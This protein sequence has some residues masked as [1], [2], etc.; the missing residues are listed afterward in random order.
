MIFEP[1]EI[2]KIFTGDYF[3]AQKKSDPDYYYC[4]LLEI[5]S[6]CRIAELTSLSKGQIKQSTDGTWFIQIRDINS[7][8][9]GC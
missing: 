4:L 3:K 1:D 5:F 6:G 7:V 9:L 2:T 8:A